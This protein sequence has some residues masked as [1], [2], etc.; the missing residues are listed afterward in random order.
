MKGSDRITTQER[1][2][3]VQKALDAYAEV[4]GHLPCPSSR[5][6]VPGGT[7]FG[8]EARDTLV[9]TN[10]MTDDAALIKV[11]SSFIGAVPTRTLGIPDTYASDAWNNKFTYVV[12]TYHVGSIGSYYNYDGTLQIQTG[13]RTGVNYPITTMRYDGN[14]ANTKDPGPGAT[15][16]VISHGMDGK[17]AYPTN[18]STVSIPC[19][20]SA[21][22]DVE[23][24]DDANLVYYDSEYNDGNV[25]ASYF[26][27]YIVWVSNSLV[28]IPTLQ[29][30]A[31]TGCSGAC[32]L[33][34]APCDTTY[35]P[36]NSPAMPCRRTIVS[37]SPCKALC[38]YA[39]PTVNIPCP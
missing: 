36:T 39:Y 22:N 37:T 21:N 24:C 31:G 4:N 3:V 1:L 9:R 30:G 14:N 20:N 18:G 13:D 28:R 6:L 38:E 32:E 17:G 5:A 34:C 25:P 11:G 33:W 23:N 10:C 12:S 29:G 26:D 15:Y 8:I 19:G 7:T 35:P 2:R 16:V 27:D